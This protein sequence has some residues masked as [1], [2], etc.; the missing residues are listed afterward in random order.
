MRRPKSPRPRAGE[1]GLVGTYRSQNNLMVFD[2]ISI[3]QGNLLNIFD[4]LFQ[5]FFSTLQIFEA[6]NPSKIE[7]FWNNEDLAPI[8]S[9]SL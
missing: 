7:I 1:S 6:H 3:V 8:R 5:K 4:E 9:F 2:G